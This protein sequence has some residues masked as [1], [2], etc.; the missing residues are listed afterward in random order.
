MPYIVFAQLPPTA[1][2][3]VRAQTEY[4]VVANITYLTATG[5]DS[6]AVTGIR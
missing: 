6:K 5:Y 3:A 1:E 4:A 2:W